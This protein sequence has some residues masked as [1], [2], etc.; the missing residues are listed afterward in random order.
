MVQEGAH[1]PNETLKGYPK[2]F[3][4]LFDQK[5]H[6]TQQITPRTQQITLFHP[7]KR[8]ILNPNIPRTDLQLKNV[9]PSG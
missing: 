3:G 7:E 4:D 9:N 1:N 5:A 6:K 8:C 2:K